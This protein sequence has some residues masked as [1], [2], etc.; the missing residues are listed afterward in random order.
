MNMKCSKLPELAV[1]A[2]LTAMLLGTPG[3]GRAAQ[4]LLYFVHPDHLNS[5]R[6][7]ADSNQTA[8]WRW[9]QDEPFGANAPNEDPDGNSVAYV[10]PLR[11]PGQYLDKETNLH[12]NYFRDYDPGTGR[13]P[14]SDPIGLA[15][16]I[17]TYSYV[18]SNP[19]RWADF[20]GL[21]TEIIQWAPIYFTEGHWGHI[22]GN[23]NGQNFSFGPR[24]WDTKFPTAEAYADR[25]LGAG[26]GGRSIIL[27]LSPIEEAFLRECLRSFDQYGEIT[28]NCGN[29]FLRCLNHLGVVD[30]RDKARVL[31]TD[32]YRI[33]SNS[34]RAIGHAAYGEG[35]PG[36]R[37]PR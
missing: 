32:V 4:E 20:P 6:L 23:I 28:N 7:V 17:N 8:V 3:T 16:G 31:P 15:G 29:P 14:Q 12:Y 34:P 19:L 10:M 1:A 22:S 18:L 24:G 35:F 5:P 11:F 27:D 21:F 33:I 30:I 9:D 13:F 37:Q 26:R 2:L 36:L 25:Q